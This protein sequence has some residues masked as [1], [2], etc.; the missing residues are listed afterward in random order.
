MTSSFQS[1]LVLGKSY[2]FH[3]SCFR[4][5][6]FGQFRFGFAVS[7]LKNCGFLVS[8]SCAVCG[9]SPVEFSLWISVFVDSD[10]GFFSVQ[11]IQYGFS[12]FAKEVTPCSRAK[13][14]IPRDHLYNILPFL[15]EARMTSLV[16][17]VPVI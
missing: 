2:S 4:F 6:G 1:L 11:C 3:F 12:G 15:L 13:P 9:F 14:V 10:C 5:C 16:C 17:L 8:V 7:A